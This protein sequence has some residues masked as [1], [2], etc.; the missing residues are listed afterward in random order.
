MCEKDYD[1]IAYNLIEN[2]FGDFR[3]IDGKASGE[4]QSI[5]KKY[6]IQADIYKTKN[7]ELI[8]YGTTDKDFGNSELEKYKEYGEELYEK[9]GKEVSIYILGSPHIKINATKDIESEA[10]IRINI[11][12]ME[13]SSTYETL[14]YLENLVKN[15][16]KLDKEDLF[17]LKMIP[18]MGPAEDKR[19]LRMECLKLWKTI[20]KK[21]LIK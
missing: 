13:Y 12:I 11:S 15:K 16:Q 17:A 4:M 2:I 7:N 9:S 10:P 21:G 1:E 18:T 3:E 6:E 8:S 5:P 14:R 19:Y 20:V